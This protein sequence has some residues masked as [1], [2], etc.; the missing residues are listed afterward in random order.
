MGLGPSPVESVLTP[1]SVRTELQGTWCLENR[2]GWCGENPPTHLT[3]GL[4]IVQ[5]GVGHISQPPG[6]PLLCRLGAARETLE[7]RYYSSPKVIWEMLP[8]HE[9]THFTARKVEGRRG[10]DLVEV[11]QWQIGK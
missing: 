5:G 7:Y 2:I 4:G 10:E 6:P 11:T 8:G 3:S 1:G 9:R